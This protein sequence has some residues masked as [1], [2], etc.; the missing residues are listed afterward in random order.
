MRVLPAGERKPEVIEP[1]IEAFT[2]DH[3]A[4]IAHVGELGQTEPPRT[5]S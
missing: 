4:E 5:G 3:D 2:G 1:M